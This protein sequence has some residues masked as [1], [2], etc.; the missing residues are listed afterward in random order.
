[1]HQTIFRGPVENP[2]VA[3]E[4]V[5]ATKNNP[6]NST[7]PPARKSRKG[8]RNLRCGVSSCNRTYEK[9]KYEDVD[10][11][12]PRSRPSRSPTS[13]YGVANAAKADAAKADAAKADAAKADAA[14]LNSMDGRWLTA[15]RTR[16]DES[17]GTK[18]RNQFHVKFE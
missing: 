6:S 8:R 16:S 10:I 11:F 2:T 14:G 3:M 5:R 17:K 13:M 4:G 7:L 1:M 15:G 18:R 12:N 9:M